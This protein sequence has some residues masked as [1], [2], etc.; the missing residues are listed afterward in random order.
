MEELLRSLLD[1]WLPSVA[2]SDD[3]ICDLKGLGACVRFV[4]HSTFL[5][6][7]KCS[8]RNSTCLSN[9][10]FIYLFL[11]N[12]WIV[13]WYFPPAPWGTP[14]SGPPIAIQLFWWRS[15][16][17]STCWLFSVAVVVRC[18][19]DCI[20]TNTSHFLWRS[21]VFLSF[22]VGECLSLLSD[23]WLSF[24]T[25]VS[26]STTFSSLMLKEYFHFFHLASWIQATSKPKIFEKVKTA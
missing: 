18:S 2:L 9:Y 12:L 11:L 6:R 19:S 15:L 8:F 23:P 20:F 14:T 24:L 22:S 25:F 1:R 5:L 17:R 13:C 16:H 26:Y 3:W 10:L 21:L 7:A 4:S